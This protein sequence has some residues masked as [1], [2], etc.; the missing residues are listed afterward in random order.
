MKNEQVSEVDKFFE[1]LPSEDKKP[2]DIFEAEE[3]PVADAEKAAETDKKIEDEN[4]GS[5]KN[6]R[7]RRMEKKLQDERES[8][9]V[10]AE[11]VRAMTEEKNAIKQN[12]DIDPRLIRIFGTTEQGTEVS[13]LLND[14]LAENTEKARQVI[15]NDIAQREE[16]SKAEL[17]REE[18]YVDSQLEAIEDA[19]DIDITS[20]TPQA[21]K[22]RTEFIELMMRLSPK[23]SSGEIR[24]YADFGTTFELYQKLNEEKIDNS[25]NKEIA[26]RSMVRSGGNSS[27][28]KPIT[29]GFNGWRQDYNLE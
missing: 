18:G 22:T 25:R 16:S 15:Q 8:N 12:P 5:H 1:E 27:Q 6:R 23:D 4:E 13:K 17:A 26:S 9:I 14:L 20:D 19:Y 24:E 28:G 10:L 7:E 3:K 2:Q 21:A 29:P 11:R